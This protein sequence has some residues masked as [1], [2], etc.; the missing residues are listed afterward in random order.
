MD[1]Y[2]PRI[3]TTLKLSEPLLFFGVPNPVIRL[4]PAYYRFPIFPWESLSSCNRIFAG[5]VQL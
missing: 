3:A 5:P 2:T 4:N 1:Q